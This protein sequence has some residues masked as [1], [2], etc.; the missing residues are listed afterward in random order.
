MHNILQEIIFG[1]KNLMYVWQ[2][3]PRAAIQSYFATYFDK[4]FFLNEILPGIFKAWAVNS[5][6]LAVF[7][8]QIWLS[9][10]ITKQEFGCLV[11]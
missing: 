8:R 11:R 6:N 4:Q 3:L 9:N 2:V 7:D 5:K 1:E 10:I